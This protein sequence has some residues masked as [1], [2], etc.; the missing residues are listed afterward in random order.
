[1]RENPWHSRFPT[2]E[3]FQWFKNLIEF[4]RL[5]LNWVTQLHP[6]PPPLGCFLL[7]REQHRLKK[8]HWTLD[9]L[10]EKDLDSLLEGDRPEEFLDMLESLLW[11]IQAHSVSVL[12]QVESPE[13][14]CSLEEAIEKISWHLGAQCAQKRWLNFSFTQSPQLPEV[15]LALK[16]SPFSNFPLNNG[17]LTKRALPNEMELELRSCPHLHLA[18]SNEVKTTTDLLCGFHFKWISGF[19][20]E[21]N[22]KIQITQSPHPIRCRQHWQLTS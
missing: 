3:H 8:Y 22:A 1:M 12:Y 9:Q 18:L 5:T 16:D 13:S 4:H 17:F 10:F 20:F 6:S 2:S 15:L 19:V 21:L 11:R 14:S 7:T